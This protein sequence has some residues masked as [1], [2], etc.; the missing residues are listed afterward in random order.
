M[1]AC[2][3]AGARVEVDAARPVY[4]K[5]KYLRTVAE[6]EECGQDIE[7]DDGAS[8]EGHYVAVLIDHDEPYDPDAEHAAAEAE[9]ED[10]RFEQYRDD[11][12]MEKYDR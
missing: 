2:I 9:E 6:C 8:E 4:V 7:V 1:T 3:G 5:G 12:L 10:R 11:R